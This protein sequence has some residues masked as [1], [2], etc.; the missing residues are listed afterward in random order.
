VE[1][2]ASLNFPIEYSR[3][4]RTQLLALLHLKKELWKSRKGLV[5]FEAAA[6]ADGKDEF[7]SCAVS[8]LS[9]NPSPLCKAP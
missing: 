4:Y 7:I 3:V 1:A 8:F 2:E 5:L 9:R 6:A